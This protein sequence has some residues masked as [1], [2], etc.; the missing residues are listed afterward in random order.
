MKCFILSFSLFFTIGLSAQDESCYCYQNPD[1]QYTE[2]LYFSNDSVVI[3]SLRG[4]EETTCENFERSHVESYKSSVGFV[5]P[6][7]KT[8]THMEFTKSVTD[9]KWNL[10]IEYFYSCQMVGEGLQVHI[11]YKP[12]FNDFGGPPDRF[13][14]KI[15][16]P[17]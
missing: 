2:W 1:N 5:W 9:P 7:T 16:L 15:E 11:D 8:E 12:N 6:Y 14:K 4:D 17:E 10:T 13:Y 3:L